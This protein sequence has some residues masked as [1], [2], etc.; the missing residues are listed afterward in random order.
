MCDKSE[1]HASSEAPTHFENDPELTIDGQDLI[2]PQIHWLNEQL[3]RA[4]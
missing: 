4:V 3:I 1:S 2:Q